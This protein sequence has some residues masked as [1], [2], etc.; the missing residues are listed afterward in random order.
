MIAGNAESAFLHV[1]PVSTWVPVRLQ[2]RPALNVSNNLDFSQGLAGWESVGHVALVPHQEISSSMAADESYASTVESY[3]GDATGTRAD[4]PAS[5]QG[6]S[7]A[8]TL[9]ILEPS[10]AKNDLFVYTQGTAYSQGRTRFTSSP[11]TSWVRIRFRFRTLEIPGGYFGTQFDDAYSIVLRSQSGGTTVVEQQSMNSIGLSGFDASGSTAWRELLVPTH[12]AGDTITAEV[13]VS[14]ASDSL[15]DSAVTVTFVEETAVNATL[16][17]RDANRDRDR[18]GSTVI[19][20][21][22][23]LSASPHSYNSG[24]DLGAT[25]VAGELRIVGEPSDTV[26]AIRLEVLDGGRVVGLGQLVPAASSALLG[27]LSRGG[28]FYDSGN[29]PLFRIPSSSFTAVRQD[30]DGTVHLRLVVEFAGGSSRQFE[31]STSPTKLLKLPLGNAT[32]YNDRD[33]EGCVGA[34]P[35]MQCGGDDWALEHTLRFVQQA[36]PTYSWNDFSNMNGGVFRNHAEHRAGLDIDGWFAGY[37]QRGALAANQLIGL[38]NSNLT[39]IQRVLVTFTPEFESVINTTDLADGRP[40]SQVF[41]TARRHT[42]HFHVD[43]NPR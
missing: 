15:Y 32:R 7:A 12:T 21:L 13:M 4:R 19:E 5:F 26:A 34:D 6:A 24:A 8:L 36:G 38:V 2:R 30:L 23:Y 1:P 16:F 41:K 40:A 37:N 10:A 28:R 17:L 18:N 42:T 43:L 39:R 22:R 33:A 14:N 11:G 35:P 3:Q 27:P 20:P 25:L 31:H 29:E 9:P